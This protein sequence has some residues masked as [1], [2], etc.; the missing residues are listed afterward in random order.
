[1]TIMIIVYGNT[2]TRCME[3]IHTY[4][5]DPKGVK[6]LTPE[7]RKSSWLGWRMSHVAKVIGCSRQQLETIQSVMCGYQLP[8]WDDDSSCTLEEKL[9]VALDYA[10]ERSGTL[11][12]SSI[13]RLASIITADV[14]ELAIKERSELSR[15]MLDKLRIAGGWVRVEDSTRRNIVLP[16]LLDRFTCC[17]VTREDGYNDAW[18]ASVMYNTPNLTSTQTFY[19]P[20]DAFKWCDA[21]LAKDGWMLIEPRYDI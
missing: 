11:H 13:S 1:M 17:V 19:T 7:S 21:A 10:V 18:S 14:I 8:T 2:H 12:D 3:L 5:L 9:W 4:G 20:T 6:L 15:Q 16:A